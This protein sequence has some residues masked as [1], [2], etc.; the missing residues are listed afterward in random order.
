MSEKLTALSPLDGRYGS[1]IKPLR[2]YFSE[3]GLM[4]YRLKIEIEYLIAL[5]NEKT[6][7]ELPQFSKRQL[8]RLRN[9]YEKFN[10]NDAQKI[11]IIERQTNH[12]VKAVEYFIH[13]KI[14]KT[15]HPWVHFALTSEDIN[16]L[17][18]SLMWKDALKQVYVPQLLLVHKYIKSLSKRYKKVPMLAL[19]HGQPATPTTFGKEMAVFYSRLLRQIEQLS[20]HELMGKFGGATG[21]WAS[22]MVAYPK[23]NWLRFSQKFIKQ[24]GLKPNLI[25]TQIECHD[26]IS[27][28]FHQVIRI[29]N[30]L[31]DLCRDIWFYISRGIITQKK[32]SGEVGSS[33]MPHKINPIQ[34]ENAE[35]NMELANKLLSHLSD[36][37]PISRMQ[38]DLTDSTTIRNQGVA[39]GHSYLG[40]TSII[41]GLSR[42]A[43]NRIQM[44]AELEN[45]WEVLAEAVQTLLRKAGQPNA[46]EQLKE[47]TR[48]KSVDVESVAEFVYKL[49]LSEQDTQT[50]LSLTPANYIGL[51]PKLPDLI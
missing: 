12:D 40:L 6:I 32:V 39:L 48:G 9:I 46:Y 35:G 1:S 28:N 49:N 17:A 14:K 51:A 11:K 33:T 3:M 15:L 25:T 41:R 42:I 21:T 2:K 29:N 44:S 27:E 37:L 34:F 47:I 24:I 45:H 8:K 10:V 7:Y 36:K 5:S 26:S 31:I 4:H 30:I 43:I 22:H 38:R 20:K 19:T 16:N 18:Y 50:L 23:L 13:D